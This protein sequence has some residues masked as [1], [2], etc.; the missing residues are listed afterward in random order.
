MKYLK[1]YILTFTVCI[2]CPFSF[3]QNTDST[4]INSNDFISNQLEN[5]SSSKDQILDY[6]DLLDEY[7][8]YYKN[9]ISINGN[10]LNK[11]VDLLIINEN[12]YQNILDYKSEYG[13]IRSE[14]ELLI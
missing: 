9:P 7:A 4:N 14:Q 6:T 13:N 12:Q 5:I 11:L 1:L 10:N 2:A 8:Y 3:S